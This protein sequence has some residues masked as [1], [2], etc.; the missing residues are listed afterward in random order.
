M[1][2]QNWELIASLKMNK[3]KLER[4]SDKG[5]SNLTFEVSIFSLQ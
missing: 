2:F 4:L 1:E 3:I 5:F